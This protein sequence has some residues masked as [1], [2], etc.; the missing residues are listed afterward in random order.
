MAVVRPFRAVTFSLDAGIDVSAHVAPP[1]DVVSPARRAAL[2]A[3]DPH[4]IIAVDLPLGGEERYAVAAETWRAWLRQGVLTQAR[5]PAFYVLEQ[6][7]TF[8]HRPIRRR[9]LIAAVDLEPFDAGVVLPHERTLPKALTD[10]LSLLRATHANLS[11]VFGLYSDPA[12]VTDELLEPVRVEPLM[13]AATDADVESSVW[14]IRDPHRQRALADALADSR[15]FIADGHHRYTTALAY[16]GERRAADGPG[17]WR[18]YDATMMALVN[19]DDP[20]LVVLPTHRVADAADPFD[21]D[22]FLAAL[23]ERFELKPAPED[24]LVP[25]RDLE[26]PPR[27]VVALRD[28]RRFVATLRDDADVSR[29]VPG[30]ASNALK[31]LD[32]TVLQELVLWPLLRIHADRPETLDRLSFVKGAEDAL[33]GSAEH[34]VTFLLRSTRMDQLRAVSMAGELMPQKSTYFYPK[35]LSGLVMRDLALD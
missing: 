23:A 16:R 20:D 28:G 19:M 14:A 9:A 33:E 11:Q 15:I 26:G 10:R 13:L 1:Y 5:S 4:D 32:V 18:P 29:D 30:N 2:L 8:R 25:L 21:P 17:G 3:R 34:D 31:S 7:F 6:R 35:L 22:A 24:F 27:F 12:G